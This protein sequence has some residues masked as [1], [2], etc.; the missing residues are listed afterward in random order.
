MLLLLMLLL[1][2]QLAPG[3]SPS[4]KAAYTAAMSADASALLP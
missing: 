4:P 1:L 2:M 3:A